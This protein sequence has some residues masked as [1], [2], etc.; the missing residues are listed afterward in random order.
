MILPNFAKRIVME[1]YVQWERHPVQDCYHICS[2]G[3]RVSVLFELP[4]DKV[5]AM[6]LIAVLARR[7]HL[8]VYCPVVMDTH[9]HLVAQG[10]PEDIASFKVQM[11]RLLTMYFHST[12]RNYLLDDGIWI[13]YTPI[14]DDI[15]LMQ[16]IIY[17]FR[18]PMDAGYP[19]LPEDYPWGVGRLFFHP[20]AGHPGQRTGNMTVRQQRELFRTRM[21]IPDDWQLDGNGM[22]LPRCFVDV[23]AVHAL[24]GSPR[25]FI[26]FLFV[27]KKDLAEQEAK[28]AR[29]F[30]QKRDDAEL[31]AEADAE[32]RRLFDRRITKLTQAERIEVARILWQNRRTLSRKQLARAVRMNPAVIEAV[33]H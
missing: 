31:H 18:N 17:V 5:Y 8:R 19:Y 6:N 4:E 20:A 25:R 9:F 13:E 27:R 32:S 16:K 1:N 26:A 33:F 14:Q 29:I 11:K 15:E 21:D 2:D 23:D 24:F 22:I 12:G 10:R 28:D 7:Y 30:L 3:T